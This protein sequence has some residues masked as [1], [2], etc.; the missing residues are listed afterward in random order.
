M[1]TG[2][3]INQGQ[4]LKLHW[5]HCF[6]K[7]PNVFLSNWI[8]WGVELCCTVWPTVFCSLSVEQ[9]SWAQVTSKHLNLLW[10]RCCY[11]AD[12]LQAAPTGSPIAALARAKNHMRTHTHTHTHTES[13]ASPV[14]P[15]HSPVRAH[16]HAQAQTQ[17]IPYA[18][19][20][21]PNPSRHSL[22][23]THS[24]FTSHTHKAH[25]NQL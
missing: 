3:I 16:I 21:K 15:W 14:R 18:H 9:L 4:E 24:Y 11:S 17:T 20:A 13:A 10:E 1:R 23:S 19:G 22:F 6:M 2:I 25:G 12:S 5:P 7:K 8:N